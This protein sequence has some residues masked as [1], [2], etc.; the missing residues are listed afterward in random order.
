MSGF[1]FA[2]RCTECGGPVEQLAP[3]TPTAKDVRAMA[4]CRACGT[5]IVIHVHIEVT[6]KPRTVGP[7]GLG[8]VLGTEPWMQFAACRGMDPELFHPPTS[9]RP[10]ERIAIETAAKAVCADCPAVQGCLRYALEH[11]L[12]FGVWG[13]M[14]AEQRRSLAV[15]AARPRRITHGTSAGWRQHKAAGETPCT[16]C[17]EAMRAESRRKRADARARDR[18]KNLETAGA[19]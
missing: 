10:A 3:G 2:L 8:A 19:A 6:T 11:R 5:E 15:E 12:Q 4:R 18:Q 1:R 14:D 7:L 16:A 9:A 17:M 13:G